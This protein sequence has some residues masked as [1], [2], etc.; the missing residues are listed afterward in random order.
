MPPGAARLLCSPDAFSFPSLFGAELLT[1]QAASVREYKESLMISPSGIDFCN[2]TVSYTHPGK[3]WLPLQDWNGRFMGVGGGGFATGLLDDDPISVAISQGYSASTTDGGH[4]SEQ[5]R[6]PWALKSPG[7]IN[8]QLLFDYASIALYDMTVIG[9][10]I[11]EQYYGKLPMYSYWNGCSTGG[12]QGLMIAQRYPEAY[13]GILASCPAVNMPSLGV[14]G[15][16]PQLVMDLLGHYPKPC[17]LEAIQNAAI[18]ECD[19]LDGVKDGVI[20]APDSCSFKPEELVGKIINCDNE[21]VNI[22]SGSA[23]IAAATWEG[24]KATDG[25]SI[26]FGSPVG[27]PLTGPIALADTLCGD[28]GCSGLPMPIA[29]DWIKMFL[30]KDPDFDLKSLSLSRFERLMHMSRQ[31]YDSILGANDP[32]LSESAHEFYLYFEVPGVGHCG[33]G[34]GAYPLHAFD[35]LRKWVEEDIYPDVLQGI[36]LMGN[37]EEE[38]HMKPICRYPLVAVKTESLKGPAFTCA[39]YYSKPGRSTQKD[40]L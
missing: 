5:L 1:I 3:I 36:H 29:E 34:P 31:Q 6:A 26:W 28:G 17:E 7:N 21:K 11:T 23:L 25:K 9:K 18:I 16:W 13:D 14:G 37:K 40:E 20:S 32:N 39:Q 35:A 10:A 24:A 15:F 30:E 22:S 2:V 4:S 27:T 19:E 33:G 38:N 12:R 8:F